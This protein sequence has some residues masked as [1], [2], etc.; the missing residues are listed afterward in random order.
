[1]FVLITTLRY[2]CCVQETAAII[3]Q[4]RC[5]KMLK[6]LKIEAEEEWSDKVI[7]QIYEGGQYLFEGKQ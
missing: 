3:I 1:M 4:Y 7:R 2:W 5:R 6:K